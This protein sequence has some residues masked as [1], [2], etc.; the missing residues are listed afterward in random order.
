PGYKLVEG[1]RGARYWTDD[2]A[3]EALL[4][5]MRV[6]VDHIYERSLIS[7]TTAEKLHKAGTLGDRQWFLVQDLIG[8][9]VGKP[10]VVPESDKRPALILQDDASQFQDLTQ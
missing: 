1:R 6:K 9:P 5:R 3:A 2:S 10:S 4:K 8:Q 7:P